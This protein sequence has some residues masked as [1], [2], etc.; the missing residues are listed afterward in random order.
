MAYGTNFL[1]GTKGGT[2]AAGWRMGTSGVVDRGTVF[3]VGNGGRAVADDVLSSGLP[4]NI[5]ADNLG[6][7]AMGSKVV[8]NDGTGAATTDR[9]GVAKAV[10][11]GT[12]AFAPDPADRTAADPQFVIMGVGTKIG[13]VANTLLQTQ[14]SIGDGRYDNMHGTIQASSG[15]FSNSAH[16]YDV[17]AR[18]STNITPNFTPEDGAQSVT[19]VNPADGTAAVTTEIFPSRSVPGELTYHFGGLGKPSTDEYKSKEVYES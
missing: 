4:V 13:G 8:T 19:L 2:F 17:T 12:L 9:V 18:P 3:G 5:N 10:S 14:G 6:D 16:S 7:R 11:G 1:L 15:S